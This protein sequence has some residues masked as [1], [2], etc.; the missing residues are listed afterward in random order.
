MRHDVKTIGGEWNATRYQ[1]LDPLKDQ[2]SDIRPAKK[3]KY[4]ISRVLALKSQILDIRPQKN[5]LSDITPP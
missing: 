2:I 5:Q 3:I 4:Q 1:I